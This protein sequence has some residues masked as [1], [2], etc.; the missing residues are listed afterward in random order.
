M[1]G[2]TSSRHTQRARDSRPSPEKPG[3]VEYHPQSDE[4]ELGELG[5]RQ[6]DNLLAMSSSGVPPA[7]VPMPPAPLAERS[8]REIADLVA[9]G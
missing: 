7:H 6:A 9:A 1:T 2:D 5:C 4:V 8:R 3:P